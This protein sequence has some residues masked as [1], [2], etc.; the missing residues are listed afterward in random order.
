MS[1]PADRFL[2][3]SGDECVAAGISLT[4]PVSLK[5]L[6]RL[7]SI[8]MYERG[9]GGDTEDVVRVGTLKD[10]RTQ[11]DRISFRFREHGQLTQSS[12]SATP[13]VFN[14]EDW[15]IPEPT[16]LSKMGRYHRTLCAA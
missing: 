16:G 4:N 1:T 2:E 8:L 6:E 14:S 12:F 5:V 11:G 9:A 3:Y 15:K 10:I 7:Q 13:H